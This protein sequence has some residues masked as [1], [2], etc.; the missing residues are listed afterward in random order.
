MQEIVREYLTTMNNAMHFSCLTSDLQHCFIFYL[1][2][3]V[4]TGFAKTK[5]KG[6]REYEKEQ[7]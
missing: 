5:R 1:R 2:F 7:S 6:R 3:W 4:G